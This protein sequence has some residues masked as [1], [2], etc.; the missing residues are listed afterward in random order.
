MALTIRKVDAGMYEELLEEDL[1]RYREAALE[2]GASQAVVLPVKDVVIDD[3]VTLKCRIP[4]CFGYGVG[5]NCPPNTL[6]PAE[7]QA[8]LDRYQW[9]LFFSVDVA[10][11][12]IVKNRDTIVERVEAYQQVYTIVSQIESMAFYDGHYLAFGLSAGSCRHTFCG[13]QK[14]CVAMEGKKCRF[15]LKSRPSLEAVG[16]DVYKMVARLGWDI[17][18]IGSCAA[19]EEVPHGTLCGLVVV[20]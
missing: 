14:D 13:Q 6:A 10:P 4:R 8:L 19:P 1:D 16:V 9:S 2:T 7:L 18:P 15:A 11:P 20:Q 3:R 17:Y 5:A 12:V